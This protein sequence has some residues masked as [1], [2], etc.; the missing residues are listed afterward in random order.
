MLSDSF[1]KLGSSTIL[2]VSGR[3]GDAALG[4]AA[5]LRSVATGRWGAWTA[6]FDCGGAGAATKPVPATI[7]VVAVAPAVSSV[8]GVGAT[9]GCA[10]AS[11]LLVVMLVTTPR[12]AGLSAQR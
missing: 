8:S 7:A 11:A 6:S 12:L 10:T 9:E 1:R 4:A 2:L 5:A 3:L